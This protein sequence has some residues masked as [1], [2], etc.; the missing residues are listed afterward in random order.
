[1]SRRDIVVNTLLGLF[2]IAVFLLP[3]LL[4]GYVLQALNLTIQHFF[5]GTVSPRILLVGFLLLCSLVSGVTNA[6]KKQWRSVFLSFAMIPVV[7]SMCLGD[8]HSPFGLQANF[9]IFGLLPILFFV[10][11]GSGPNR[12]QF[13]LAASAIC[14]AIAINTGLLG[15]GPLSRIVAACVLDGALLWFLIGVR[16]GWSVPL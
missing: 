4:T 8:P 16:R 10:P 14:A 3:F 2:L 5:P 12:S 7:A 15:S 13:F 11:G 1:M 6:R 9:W